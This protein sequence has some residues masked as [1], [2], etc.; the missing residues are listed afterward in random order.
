MAARISLVLRR[1]RP[2]PLEARSSNWRSRRGNFVGTRFLCS[3]ASP[4]SD[5]GAGVDADDLPSLREYIAT[6]GVFFTLPEQGVT[7][8]EIL[9]RF[10]ILVY[11]LVKQ[12]IRP[13]LWHNTAVHA[14][15]YMHMIARRT[16]RTAVAS[17]PRARNDFDGYPKRQKLQLCM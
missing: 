17:Y 11:W 12:V 9:T 6:L 4:S 14:R 5:A 1:C 8:P 2:R 7:S 16:I 13:R 15:L 3:S 10:D